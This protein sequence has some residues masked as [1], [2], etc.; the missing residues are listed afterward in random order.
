LNYR[1]NVNYKFYY[2]Y[3]TVFSQHIGLLLTV[4]KREN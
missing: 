3:S 4:T 2:T 1:S